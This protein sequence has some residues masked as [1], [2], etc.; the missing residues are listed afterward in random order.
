MENVNATKFFVIRN[1]KNAQGHYLIDDVSS[2]SS[3]ECINT[4][5]DNQSSPLNVYTTDGRLLRR[6]PAGTSE[7]DALNSL[8]RGM[9]IVNGKKLVK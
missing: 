2:A 8:P 5:T 4:V 3:V 7:S 9:Y 6:L 1:E